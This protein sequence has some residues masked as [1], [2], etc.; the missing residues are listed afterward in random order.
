[1]H[2]TTTARHYELAPAL[3]EY[4][5]SKILNLKKYFDNIVN[6]HIIF[7]LEKY[8]HTVEVTLH[9]NGKDFNGKVESEN[10]YTSVDRVIEK[11]ERQIIKHKGKRYKKKTPRLAEIEM[12]VPP[13]ESEMRTMTPEEEIV[14]ADPIEFPKLSLSEAVSKLK[15]NGREFSIFSNSL[16]SR[17]NVLYV[18]GDGTFGLIE[19]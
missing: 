14:P 5:E 11:L 18:R 12:D 7:A 8:R 4:A 9:A 15:E 1:M 3:K 10:M 13:E 16:T 6:A 19:A 17:L 2:I